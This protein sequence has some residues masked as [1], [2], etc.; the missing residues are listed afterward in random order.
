M[1]GMATAPPDPQQIIDREHLRL[2]AIFHYVV[3][4]IE[5]L[6]SSFAIIHLIARNCDDRRSTSSSNHPTARWR[7]DGFPHFAGYFFATIGGFVLLFG[8][9]IGGLTI[10]SGRCIQL[11][12]RRLLSLIMAG[13]N[14]AWIPFGTIL[15]VFSFIVLARPSVQRMYEP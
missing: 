9:T 13:I 11:R 12:R 2:L 1:S 3:G 8:W 4:G 5:V 6:F 14:C 15:G 7:P 10:Y